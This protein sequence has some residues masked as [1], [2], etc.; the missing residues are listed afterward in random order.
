MLFVFI[1]RHGMSSLQIVRVRLVLHGTVGSMS[2]C[3]PVYINVTLHPK[4]RHTPFR[5][6]KF[7]II[8]FTHQ[9]LFSEICKISLRNTLLLSCLQNKHV[10]QHI[11]RETHLKLLMNYPPIAASLKRR[12]KARRMRIISHPPRISTN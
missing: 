3:I 5:I 4:K 9:I 7:I 2:W 8:F 10:L 12:P 1:C 11:L 6:C